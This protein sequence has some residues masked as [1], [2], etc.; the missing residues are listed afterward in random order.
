MRVLS[1]SEDLVLFS[2][3]I[4]LVQIVSYSHSGGSGGVKTLTIDG[5]R[6]RFKEVKHYSE[7]CEGGEGEGGHYSTNW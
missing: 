3:A 2:P 1:R 5:H 4:R 6:A 7:Q